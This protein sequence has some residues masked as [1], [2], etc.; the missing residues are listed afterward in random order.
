MEFPAFSLLSAL[1]TQRSTRGP[2]ALG[3]LGPGFS[4]RLRFS[5]RAGLKDRN[6]CIRFSSASRLLKRSR[7]MIEFD[8]AVSGDFSGCICATC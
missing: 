3:E 5:L 6:I 1:S 8:Q 4:L 2:K 7:A